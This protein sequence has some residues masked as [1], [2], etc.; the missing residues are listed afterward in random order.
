MLKLDSEE[1]L[2]KHTPMMQ[3]YLRIKAKH[4]NALVFYRMG[5]FYE[6]FL[7]DA[8]KA[9]QLLDLTLTARGKASD[10]P[11]PMA[12]V[13]YHSADG[14]LAKLVKM[15]ESVAICEQIGDPNTSKG[16]VERQVVRIVTPGTV[17]DESL[18]PAHTDNLLVAVTGDNDHY[19]IAS[20][21]LSG[22]Y[23]T[24]IEVDSQASLDA[25]LQRLNPSE[26]LLNE[27]LDS[28][29]FNIQPER[30]R[31]RASWEFEQSTAKRCL[32]EQ[33]GTQDLKAFGCEALTQAIGAAGCILAYAKET[34]R[35]E[36][37]H[38]N[39]IK[40]EN[41]DDSVQMD[42]STRRNLEIDRNLNGEHKYTLFALL[43]TSATPMGS[44]L[45]CRWLNRP[46]RQLDTLTQRQE[47]IQSLLNNYHFEQLQTPL[48]AIGDVERILGRIALRSARPRD[49]SRLSASLAEY[50][51]IQ[52]VLST[53]TAPRLRYLASNI[54][55][56]PTQLHLLQTAIIENPPVVIRDGGVI[57]EGY[58]QELDELRHISSHAGQFLI[59]LETQERE[60]TGIST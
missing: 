60:R 10:N 16:P 35:T 3:Q 55:T 21:D 27:A 45:L 22:G 34:Q 41:R 36:L 49:L 2:A 58:D 44:R 7:D 15:G 43:D 47:A 30:L 59:D 5:D 46:L 18:L 19:G 26:L 20:L 11:I 32:C 33:F 28:L 29:T 9:A 25:E 57:A 31:L 13:P 14:Y 53:H 56:F 48:K 37:P 24:V 23:F 50:P 38:I 54:Q 40:K 42:A 39:G 51:Q 12:G 8:T 17:T 52:T 1:N 4:M 6:L